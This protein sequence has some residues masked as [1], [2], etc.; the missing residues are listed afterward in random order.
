MVPP[1]GTA[2]TMVNLWTLH[3][4][5]TQWPRNGPKDCARARSRLRAS[6]AILPLMS[7]EEIA[8]GI[9]FV[10]DA[11]GQVTSV[12]LTPELWRRVVEQIEDAEDRKLLKELG[13]KLARGP[14]GA[15]KWADVE[16]D[17]A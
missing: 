7:S 9:R 2:S 6:R 1:R 3:R 16:R 10:V 11:E 4:L 15:I 17:W 8:A 14:E 12:V 13:P 5:A